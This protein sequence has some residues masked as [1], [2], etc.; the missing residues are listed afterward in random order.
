MSHAVSRPTSSS[1]Q[2]RQDQTY[3]L[4]KHAQGARAARTATAPADS[5]YQDQDDLDCNSETECE[6]PSDHS[7]IAKRVAPVPAPTPVPEPMYKHLYYRPDV[8]YVPT[9]EFYYGAPSRYR[10]V[11]TPAYAP[12]AQLRKP[13]QFLPAR[14]MARVCTPQAVS[15]SAPIHPY[16]QQQYAIPQVLQHDD[17][18]MTYAA[19]ANEGMASLPVV[20]HQVS[21]GAGGVVYHQA[22]RHSS[23]LLQVPASPRFRASLNTVVSAAN[24]RPISQPKKTI[25]APTPRYIRRSCTNSPVYKKPS[26]LCL[27]P[28]TCQPDPAVHRRTKPY[29]EQDH[30][31]HPKTLNKNQQGKRAST[32]QHDKLVPPTASLTAELQPTLSQSQ[33]DSLFANYEELYL[34]ATTQGAVGQTQ[35]KGKIMATMMGLGP[36]RVPKHIQRRRQ[37]LLRA[38]KQSD[39]EQSQLD[40][41][42]SK[43]LSKPFAIPKDAETFDVQEIT[44]Q[45]LEEL[46]NDMITANDVVDVSPCGGRGDKLADNMADEMNDTDTTD[47]TKHDVSEQID[48][49]LLDL[50]VPKRT[51]DLLSPK[52]TMIESFNYQDISQNIAKSKT[53]FHEDDED[54]HSSAT[55]KQSTTP[56]Q[57]HLKS[58]GGSTSGQVRRLASEKS[59]KSLKC[60]RVTNVAEAME[61]HRTKS[62]V[63]NLIDTALSN[64]FGTSVCD[65]YSSYECSGLNPVHLI[66]TLKK[67]SVPKLEKDVCIEIAQ[68]LTQTY[69]NQNTCPDKIDSGVEDNSK[70]ESCCSCKGESTE[71]TYIKYLRQLR[72]GHLKHIQAEAK[73]LEEL[74]RFF[75]SCSKKAFCEKYP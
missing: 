25:T 23:H 10:Y 53:A 35:P 44:S 62:Y 22:Q 36:P 42:D 67:H 38:N 28:L 70:Q 41:G 68:A 49:A 63:V 16:Y 26:R 72:W 66:E 59:M 39:K 50:H 69:S 34:K 6:T 8:Q 56:S 43:E 5:Y 29:D 74:E 61:L 17:G 2:Q 24:M 19:N 57:G 37:E 1:A 27:G 52:E 54:E 45:V 55:Q 60:S 14:P 46:M 58:D 21:A 71:P 9:P 33:L 20:P 7:Q 31:Q 51:K 47:C 75:D 12:V 3:A 65:K 73:R 18:M 30:E 64:H 48:K 32:K 15:A 4:S 40:R 11:T 13:T